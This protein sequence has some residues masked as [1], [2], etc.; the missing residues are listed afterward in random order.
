MSLP[1]DGAISAFYNAPEQAHLKAVIDGAEK[2]DVTNPRFPYPERW[3]KKKYEKTLDDLQIELVKL[4]AWVRDTGARVAIVFEGRDAAG[5]GGT[6]KRLRANLNPRYAR[7]VALSKPT[8]REQGQ[9]YFQRYAQHLPTAGEIVI[10]DRSWYN[11]GV[12]EHV[13]DFC[14]PEQRARWF[15]Q[16]NPFEKQLVDDGIH[17]FKFWLNVGQATQLE[18]FLKRESDPLKQWKLSWID[19]EGLNRWDAYSDAIHETLTRTDTAFSPWTVI[20]G[21]DKRRARVGAIREVLDALPYAGKSGGSIPDRDPRIVSSV[22]DWQSLW[23][24]D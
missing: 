9:W 6:I 11:R 10:F 2:D 18:R 22:D 23:T 4:L 24:R 20:K 8:E 19:V 12:V 14:T 3:D 21:D 7:V 15:E 16:V 5:K 13:F 17:L 1:F